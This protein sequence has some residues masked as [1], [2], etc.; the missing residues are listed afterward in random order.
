MPKMK[1]G[2]QAFTLIELL[3]VICIIAILAAMLLPALQSARDSASKAT[4]VNNLAQMSK[5]Y[6]MYA[7]T[8]DDYMPARTS[9]YISGG[10]SCSWIEAMKEV[11]GQS[12]KSTFD[13]VFYCEADSSLDEVSSTPNSGSVNSSRPKKSYSLNNLAHA[14][15]PTIPYTLNSSGRIDESSAPDM[16]FISGN[17]MTAVRTPSALIVIGE[18]VAQNN[19]DSSV[20]YDISDST[21]SSG[22]ACA[23]QQKHSIIRR[24]SVHNT[25]GNLYLDGHTSHDYP[26]KTVPV[27]YTVVHGMNSKT[28][29]MPSGSSGNLTT[30][31]RGDWTDCANRKKGGSCSGNNCQL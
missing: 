20:N 5:A 15:H 6:Q 11:M 3:V 16:G 24:Q 4:C 26:E 12:G 7:T 13:T 22:T 17:R 28:T 23:V 25:A 8:Y 27:Y 29:S 18:N 2:K 10:G 31:G 14:V 19:S 9:P 1:H 21:K 30:E